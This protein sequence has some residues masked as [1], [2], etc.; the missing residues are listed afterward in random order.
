MKKIFIVLCNVFLAL[1]LNSY[2]M[3]EENSSTAKIE[4]YLNGLVSGITVGSV[5]ITIDYNQSKLRY[6]KATTGS[7]SAGSTLIANDGK[8]A[9]RVGLIHAQG[10][11]GGA[12]GSFM[13]LT[14]NVIDGYKPSIHDFSVKRIL[15][16]DLSG[17]DLHIDIGKVKLSLCGQV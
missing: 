15:V 6:I 17:K 11:D 5:D 4:I 3:E 7:L 14:F 9:V 16:T 1:S 12:K 8:D 13:T 10:F 2:A